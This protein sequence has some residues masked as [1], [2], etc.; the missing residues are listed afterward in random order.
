[1]ELKEDIKLTTRHLK[2]RIIAGWIKPKELETIIGDE[3]LELI[4]SRGIDDKYFDEI[5]K[6]VIELICK[7]YTFTI[8]DIK[9]SSG[10]CIDDYTDEIQY[11]IKK[12]KKEMVM[13][14]WKRKGYCWFW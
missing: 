9:F 1:M 13:N 7:E 10:I 5:K 11:Y 3:V 4:F 14:D 2:N 8:E 6:E 12:I